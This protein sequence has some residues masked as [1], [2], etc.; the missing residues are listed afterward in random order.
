M[1]ADTLKD[2]KG[3]TITFADHANLFL[4]IDPTS[5]TPPGMEGGDPIDTTSLSNTSY[6]TKYPQSLMEM[7]NGSFTAAYDPDAMEDAYA[8][9]NDNNLIT[10]TFPDGMAV[11]VWGYLKT[12]TPGEVVVGEQPTAECE[13]VI[14]LENASSVETAPDWEAGSA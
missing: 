9:I 6:R 5:I 8:A 7:T 2:G 11:A 13:I 4:R 3:T 1:K 12:F 10:F 14:T